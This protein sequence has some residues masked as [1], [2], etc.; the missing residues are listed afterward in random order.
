[1]NFLARFFRIIPPRSEIAKIALLLRLFASDFLWKHGVNVLSRDK[2]SL[3][4]SA[5]G[6]A[7]TNPERV[8]GQ[9]SFSSESVHFWSE[10]LFNCGAL[11]L[12]VASPTFHFHVIV[13]C[14][15]QSYSFLRYQIYIFNLLLFVHFTF[16]FIAVWHWIFVSLAASVTDQVPSMESVYIFLREENSLAKNDSRVTLGYVRHLARIK[17]IVTCLQARWWLVS[18]KWNDFVPWEF[19]QQCHLVSTTGLC[20][21]ISDPLQNRW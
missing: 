18:A 3:P 10:V 15:F 9:R 4:L 11:S 19:F 7:D 5:R 13:T 14:S 12:C 6:K 20:V 1:M 2:T 8:P 16:F 21:G 17:K